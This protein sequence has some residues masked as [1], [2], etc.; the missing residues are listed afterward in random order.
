MPNLTRKQI[1]DYKT[2][3]NYIKKIQEKR[4]KLMGKIVDND[5]IQNYFKEKCTNCRWHITGISICDDDE[6]RGKIPIEYEWIEISE[7][8]YDY[9]VKNFKI[10]SDNWK[11][12]Y[13]YEPEFKEH[14]F[15]YQKKT[16]EYLRVYVHESWS[17]GGNDDIS[18]DFL[19]TDILD[20]KDLRK[21]KLE[22]LE[23][24]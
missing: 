18:H 8:E 21:E 22:K 7:E 4:Q 10:D 20:I 6:Y 17:Y 11:V 13:E 24:V 19:L 1:S 9:D 5:I 16:Y 14:Y 3:Q 15:R 23:R 2:I 12:E